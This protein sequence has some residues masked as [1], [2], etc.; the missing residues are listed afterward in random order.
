MLKRKIHRI[1]GA[2]ISQPHPFRRR[3]L[4]SKPFIIAVCAV[5]AL[6][7]V[8][9]FTGV[10]DIQGQAD[11]WNMFFITRVPRTAALMLTGAAMS[12]SG[13]VTQL[14]TQNRLVEPTTTGTIEWAGLGLVFVYLAVPAPT[15][16]LRMT[17]AILFSFIGTMIFFLFLRRVKLRSSL[18]VP[19]IGMM[20]GAVISAISTFIG[21]VF[22]MTQSIEMWF[23]GSFA[24]VQIGRYE[25]L[26]LIVI[27]NI[28]IFI[29][30][31][32]LTLAGLGEDVATSLG[33]NYNRIVILGTCLISA[34]VGIV[35]AVIGNLPFLGLIVPNIVSM[36]RGDDLKSNLPWVCV[37]G[38]G[39]VTLCD[40]ISR[41]IIMPF[42]V[43]VSLILGTVGA[44]V[45][46]VILLKQRKQR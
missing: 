2:E 35:A 21:L 46:I 30:A 11:G 4:W 33:V 22:Q 15:L 10:Y 37:L 43:P 31:D 38:M 44:V 8:S 24:S 27:V 12:M 32:R 6:G 25:Y 23:V 41:T 14:I 5:F 42:E 28:I 20:L 26:W 7:V 1:T 36:Y 18:I 29:Y 45:F 13:L 40:I 3:K 19:I 16:M 9:L 34:A 39:V 17:G